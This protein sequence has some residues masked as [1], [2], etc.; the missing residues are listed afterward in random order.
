MS[1]T[2]FMLI[3]I[4]MLM[5]HG[6]IVLFWH[7]S[8]LSQGV[9]DMNQK[10]TLLVQLSV[11][12]AKGQHLQRSLV[13]TMEQAGARCAI[14]L[15]GQAELFGEDQL[16]RAGLQQVAKDVQ[17]SGK[18]VRRYSHNPV[19]ALLNPKSYLYV[20]VPMPSEEGRAGVIGCGV[21][22]ARYWQDLIE[23][24]KVIA[25]Y[26]LV[27]TIILTVV[28]FFRMS[29]LI[30]RPMDKLVS[31]VTAY[32]MNSELDGLLVD[33]GSSEFGQLSSA[34]STMINTIHEDRDALRN[35]I[36][37]LEKVNRTLKDTRSEMIHTEKL[38]AVGK[39]S[40]GLAHEIGNPL[41]VVIGYLGLLEQP[42]ISKADQRDYLQRA[43]RELERIHTLIRQLLDY[44]RAS[45]ARSSAEI[46]HLNPVIADVAALLRFKA[47][48]GVLFALDLRGEPDRV[49]ADEES[50]RQVLI[51]CLLN[52]MEAIGE[53]EPDRKGTVT[54]TTTSVPF[55]S[56]K[57]IMLTIEDNGAGV[58]EGDLA[59]V[60]DPFFTTKPVG[61]GTGLGLSVSAAIVHE[62]GGTISMESLHGQGA[63]VSVRLPVADAAK[64]QGQEE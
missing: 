39:L 28:A 26:L 33:K 23:D 40:A 2:S 50:L 55:E 30:L 46:V 15:S 58:A 5:A 29:K 1:M 8:L 13:S 43:G 3:G 54:V 17:A 10:L 20:A 47:D 62:L 31:S 6:V 35:T 27:N 63:R 18:D 52:A 64:E 49:V 41:G 59:V 16:C 9:A 36:V 57:G 44:S 24:Q 60:F 53:C 11:Q 32:T 25:V 21:P 22:L 37:E 7:A 34:L 42:D 56:S 61:S 45:S 51:N 12:D 19:L 4:G 48:D 38:A 14:L